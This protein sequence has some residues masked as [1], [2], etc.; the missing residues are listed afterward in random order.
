MIRKPTFKSKPVET[1]EVATVIDQ[2][3]ID[4]LKESLPKNFH[5]TV[6]TKLVN[7]VNSIVNDE[8]FAEMFRSN[9]ITYQSVLLN[10]KYT[11]DNYVD[12]VTYCSFKFMGMSDKDAYHNAFPDRVKR[13]LAEGKTEKTISSY[14]HAY[15]KGKLVTDLM[16]QASIP[17]Y[18]LYQ[19]YFH[20]AVTKQA[21]LMTTATSEMVQ[22]QAANSLLVA[23]KQPEVSKMQISATV[24][25]EGMTA[26]E[27][28]AQATQAF[29]Q[30]QREAIKAGAM[31]AK[32]VAEYRII[33]AEQVE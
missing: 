1:T 7:T 10:G 19:D 23:L 5:S 6:T 29:V 16:A 11:V 27:S 28:L 21:Q 15:A 18:L 31:T 33:E 2:F 26:I 12:A 14:V 17:N 3:T 13:L 32:G 9:L 24:K 25:H 30:Q 22:M 8:Q 4:T 20:K